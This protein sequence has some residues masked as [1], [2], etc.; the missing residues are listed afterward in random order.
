VEDDAAVRQVTARALSNA[1]FVVHSAEGPLDALA[2]AGGLVGKVDAIVSDIV[3][4]EMS[5]LELRGRLAQVLGDLP[6][7]FVSGYSADALAQRGVDRREIVLVEKPF[8]IEDL[9]H[10]LLSALANEGSPKS[11]G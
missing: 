5:G 8:K 9:V 4:P 6:T 2:R 11:G 7:V 10:P 3:M 1:G